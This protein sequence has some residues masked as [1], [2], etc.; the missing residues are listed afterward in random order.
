MANKTF[1]NVKINITF[2]TATDHTTNIASGD[3]IADSLGKIAKWYDDFHA[4]VWSGDAATVNGKTVAANVP[5]NAKFTDTTYTDMTAATASA[6]G[7]HGLVP[8]PAAGKQNAFL[9]GDGTWVV[10]TNTTYTAATASKLGLVKSGGDVTV[11]T[12]GIMSVVDN[13]HNH[14]IANVTGLQDALD[15]KISTSLKGTANGVAEL[16][17]DGKVPSTQLPSYVDDVI[18]GYLNAGKFYKESSHTTEITAESGKIYVDSATNKTY[19]W[20]GTAYVE[21]S[22]SL[23]LGETSS[24]AYRGDRGKTAYDHSQVKTGNPHNVTKNDVGLGN[25]E[26]KSSATIR[27]EITKANVTDALGYTP[28]EQDTTYS[29]ATTSTAGLMSASDKTKLNGIAAGAEVNQN[30]VANIKVG[31]VIVAANAKIDTFELVGSTNVTLEA[32]ATTKKITIKSANTTYTAMTAATASAAGKSGLVPVPPA[33]SQ[34]KFLTGAGTW[35]S[36]S[37][38]SLPV[39]S[40]TVL[41]GVKVGA[42]LNIQSGVLYAKTLVGAT[43]SNA[44]TAGYAPTPGTDG[45]IEYTSVNNQF[46]CGD[47]T[48]SSKPVIEEDTLILNCVAD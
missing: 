4:V 3:N 17:A 15:D 38:Y 29:A 19:R 48:W 45:F 41:G 24:T 34:N 33:G 47:G 28:P 6:A 26:N 31:D 37:E 21:I 13:S 30:A 9:R 11:G 32:D 43:A 22:A 23:A 40:G 1:N 5:A 10:P 12:D 14:T 18:E 36:P 35:V 27:G 39:A 8:A 16:D 2:T 42:S 20:S 7:T 44:G 25:V 46:L